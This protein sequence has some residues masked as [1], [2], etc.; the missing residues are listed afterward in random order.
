MQR[1][2][3]RRKGG[4]RGAQDQFFVVRLG[5]E[6]AQALAK[7]FDQHGKANV[8]ACFRNLKATSGL[9]TRA[10]WEILDPDMTMPNSR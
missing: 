4:Q 10:G 3:F 9:Q 6:G 5:A 7:V 1:L 2:P 8:R